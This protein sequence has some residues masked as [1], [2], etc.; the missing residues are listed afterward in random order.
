[1]PFVT[2]GRNALNRHSSEKQ[3]QPCWLAEHRMVPAGALSMPAGRDGHAP[4][5]TAAAIRSL[6]SAAGEF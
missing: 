3:E 5:V 2:V 6:P 4:F 1:M